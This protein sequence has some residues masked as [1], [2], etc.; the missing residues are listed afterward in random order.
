MFRSRNVEAG[1]SLLFAAALVFAV[2]APAAAAT[3]SGTRLCTA[4]RVPQLTIN[5]SA[6]GTGVWTN[7][8]TAATSQFSFPGGQSFRSS[9]YSRANWLVTNGSSGF[10]Y[11][12]PSA[13]CP[14]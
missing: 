6:N 12:A 7:Y 9:P 5:S 11:S 4:P 3:A 2:A 14:V 1:V 10:Y 8:D 13:S